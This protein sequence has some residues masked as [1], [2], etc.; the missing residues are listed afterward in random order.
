MFGVPVRIEIGPK[1]NDTRIVTL[2]RR[3]TGKKNKSD[4]KHIVKEVICLFT[5]I[6]DNLK[7]R[8]EKRMENEIADA[9]NLE[10]LK[11]LM[12]ERKIVRVNWC[13][14]PHC[15]YQLKDEVAG[16][17]RGTLWGKEKEVNRP[18][19]VCGDLAKTIAYVSRTY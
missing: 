4:F 12:D 9:F 11:K 7:A 13:E 2:V 3:D 15:A 19:I 10:E 6:F 1:E 5:E 18:C 16:E 17:V 14:D 8:S